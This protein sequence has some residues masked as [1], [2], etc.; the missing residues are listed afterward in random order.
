MARPRGGGNLRADLGILGN[1][2]VADDYHPQKE[3]GPNRNERSSDQLSLP[4]G[5]IRISVRRFVSSFPYP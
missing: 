4:C 3:R 5:I 1:H 2:R